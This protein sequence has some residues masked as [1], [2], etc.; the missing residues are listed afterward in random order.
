M[1]LIGSNIEEEG[2]R[3]GLAVD[4]ELDCGVE[5]EEGEAFGGVEEDARRDGE[6]KGHSV[7][8]AGTRAI[9]NRCHCCCRRLGGSSPQSSAH[10]GH[11]MTLALKC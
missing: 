2:R 3:A 5:A 10:E 7:L 6:W 4:L 8:E 1:D 11:R 9:D